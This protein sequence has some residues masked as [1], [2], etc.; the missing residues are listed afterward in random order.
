VERALPRPTPETRHF[1]DGTRAGELRLQRCEDCGQIYF[2]PRP[3]CPGCAS[4]RVTVFA[5]SGR[6]RLYSY[7]IHQR[8]APGF[9]PP[10]VIALVELAEGPRM[11]SNLVD[12]E[13]VPEALPL[14]LALA[15]CFERIDDEITLPLFRPAGRRA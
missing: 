8:P 12:V 15:V 5:A 3:V 4:L 6:A 7:V 9:R 1:W 11:L 2:P 10:Y 13:P 14:D